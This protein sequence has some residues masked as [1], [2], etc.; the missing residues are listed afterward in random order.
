[1]LYVAIVVLTGFTFNALGW[2]LYLIVAFI[3]FIFWIVSLRCKTGKCLS[4]NS[5]TYHCRV[6]F[7]EKCEN[8]QSVFKHPNQY[9]FRNLCSVFF[10]HVDT[11]YKWEK[12]E[13][14][15]AENV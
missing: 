3:Q 13:S 11:I 15:L 6:S 14:A 7:I 4:A 12:L 9:S 1:M 2:M 8:F 10:K 5:E